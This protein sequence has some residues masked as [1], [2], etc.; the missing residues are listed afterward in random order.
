MEYCIVTEEKLDY[1][2][3]KYM[4]L[5]KKIILIILAVFLIAASCLVWT[6]WDVLMILKTG[7]TE[8]PEM[9]SQKIDTQE[10]KQQ[11]AL[12]DAGVTNVRPLDEEEKKELADGN[13]TEDDAVKIVTGQV[14]MEDIKNNTNTGGET[15]KTNTQETNQENKVNN[16]SAQTDATNQKVAELVGKIYV[17]EARFTSELSA[18][19]KWAINEYESV[20]KAEKPNKKKELQKVGFPKLAQLEKECDDEVEIVLAELKSVLEKAGQST[21]LV[22]QIREAYQDKK[23]LK[24]SFYIS[25]YL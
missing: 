22:N 7:I 1:H 2:E 15:S 11:R 23:V 6:F 20:S 13:I 9:I 10:T 8:T 21:D 24:K 4:T 25:E 19:E 17:L 12:Q 14:T 18:L 5:K 16:N 3:V